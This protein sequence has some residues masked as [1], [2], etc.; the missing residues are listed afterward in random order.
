MTRGKCAALSSDMSKRPGQAFRPLT[1]CLRAPCWPTAS[2]EA[3][4]QGSGASLGG[5]ESRLPPEFHVEVNPAR[6][7]D[8][9]E[10]DV[11]PRLLHR[12]EIDEALD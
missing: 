2:A 12:D 10:I 11:V 9:L 4:P 3:G 8:D 1:L 6:S 7:A 5:E